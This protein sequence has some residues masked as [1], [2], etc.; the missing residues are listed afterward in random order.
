VKQSIIFATSSLTSIDH[1]IH[2]RTIKQHL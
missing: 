2:V 1:V